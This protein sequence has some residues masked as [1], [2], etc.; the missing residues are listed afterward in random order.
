MYAV[1]RRTWDV[2]LLLALLA[3]GG[4]VWAGRAQPLDAS[5]IQPAVAAAEAAPLPGHPAP[6]FALDTPDGRRLAL[7]ELRGQ[8][9]LVNVWATWCPPCRAEMPA[10]QAAYE[11]Y[12]DQGFAVLAVNMR[13][14]PEDVR[15]FMAE[16]GLTFETPLDSDGLVSAAY[17]ARVVPSS[18]FIDR[19]GVIRT[20]YRGP[21]PHS[22]I[23]GTVE[24]LLAEAP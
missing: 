4:L 10:I 5:P 20:V 14:Q 11:Q 15:A 8:V 21:I 18:Y 9:V 23:A 12:R 24:Q 22:A 2:L 16:R 7:S 1:N 19:R 3:G 13:E 17:Q 6:D